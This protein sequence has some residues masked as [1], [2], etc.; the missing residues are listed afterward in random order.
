MHQAFKKFDLS[1][2]S[3][4][5]TG[6]GSGIGY[7]MARGL[8]RS[9]ARVMIASRRE[10]LLKAGGVTVNRGLIWQRSTLPHH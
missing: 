4:F 5:V 10:Q 7:Y 1:G 6:G 2:K 8:A 9:G 3:A